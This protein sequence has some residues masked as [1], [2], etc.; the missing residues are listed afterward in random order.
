MTHRIL[1]GTVMVLAC[2]SGRPALAIRDLDNQ[3]CW[4]KPT[5]HNLPDKE[6]PGF[7]VNL[8]PT[9]ARGVLT[10]RSF[11]VKY[12]FQGSPAVGR[13]AIDDEIVGVFDKPFAEHQ[14]GG[15]PHGYEGPIMDLGMA[16]EKAEGVDGKLVLNVKNG[17]AMKKVTVNLQPIGAFSPTFPYKCKKSTTIR[18]N[19]LTYLASNPDAST[20]WQ[21]HA[22]SAVAL[23]LLTSDVPQQQAAGKQMVLAWSQQPPDEG[24]WTWSLSYQLI[25]LSEYYL[26]TKDASVLPAIKAD[27]LRLEHAQYSGKLVV[28]KAKPEEDQAAI[29]AAQQLYD[30]GFGHGPYV[31]AFDKN[32]YGPMQYTTILAVTAWQLA[33]RCGVEAKPGCIRRALDF[34]HRGTNEAGY[35]AY[36]G[37]FTLNNGIV[38]SVAWRSSTDGDNYSGR[39]GAAIVAHTLSP[40][41]EDSGPYLQ[42][43]RRY[44]KHAAKSMP[45]GH[46]DS[47]LGIFWGL[48]GAAV[49]ED[50]SVLRVTFDYHKAFFNMMRC[51]DGSFVLLPGRD[52]ADN[53]YYMGSRY[54]PTGTMALAFGLAHPKLLIQGIQASIPGVN[55]KALTGQSELAYKA[56]VAKS[57]GNAAKLLKTIR[58]AKKA[59]PE[60]LAAADAML[61][62][63]NARF[64]EALGQLDALEKRQDLYAL[65]AAFLAFKKTYS[66]LDDFKEKTS[67]YEDALKQ[68]D[69][70]AAIKLGG[71]Y[72]QT[73]ATLKRTRSKTAIDNLERFAEENPDSPYGKWAAT[74][75]QEFR[76][77]GVVVDPSEES[78]ALSN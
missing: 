63:V 52:Y 18:D 26:L 49:S 15:E 74:V 3:G 2:C 17:E 70:R 22:R 39:S 68:P 32:G 21:A 7:L 25:T 27:V 43:Y 64:E 6:V 36:G 38:D 67:R 9:G 40:E 76:D 23:A 71:R 28:W 56:I 30:G 73:M 46:A 10:A 11:I 4:T 60:E 65:H 55:P 77:N 19:A 53:G 12:V 59:S 61:A 50:I 48:M 78:P 35:V 75:V 14:F 44:A 72:A 37:E 47:N 16:I 33:G 31:A 42:K 54:H 8:G 5:E 29:D 1:V 20:V 45:D 34:I 58:T 57:Y 51:F 62:F 13:L 24:T 41:F 66:A 69:W